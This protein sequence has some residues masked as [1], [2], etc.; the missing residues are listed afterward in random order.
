M[1]LR[2]TVDAA[3]SDGPPETPY[4]VL[5]DYDGSNNLIYQG[6][7]TPGT[8][9]S[10]AAWA[11]KKNT[12]SGSNLTMSQWANGKS[13]QENIWDARADLTYK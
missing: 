12:F 9:T 10:A 5:Y 4:L 13:N 6:F 2:Q 1:G 3:A 8:A 7:A 11:I